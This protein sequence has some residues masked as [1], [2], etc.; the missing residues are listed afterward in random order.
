MAELRFVAQRTVP[1]HAFFAG[2]VVIYNVYRGGV[3]LGTV[4]RGKGKRG[5]SRQWYSITPGMVLVDDM[6]PPTSRDGAAKVLD[7]FER[8]RE[9]AAQ[10][11]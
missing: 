8:A 5:R 11:T 6:H 3:H 10:T 4:H 2:A 7:Q 9:R 1:S